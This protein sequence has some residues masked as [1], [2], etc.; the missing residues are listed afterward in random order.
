MA[1]G[2]IHIDGLDRFKDHF[3]LTVDPALIDLGK[4][5]EALLLPERY[6]V[7]QVVRKRS[8]HFDYAE[9][10]VSS[11]D[12]LQGYPLPN[13]TPCYLN[14]NSEDGKTKTISLHDILIN[15][16]SAIR[17]EDKERKVTIEI[18][19]THAS[20]DTQFMGFAKLLWDEISDIMAEATA[21]GREYSINESEIEY[22][23]ARRAYDFLK[24]GFRESDVWH[25][26]GLDAAVQSIP[27]LTEWP[28]EP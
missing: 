10:T 21:Y 19:D 28:S 12:I 13:V 18:K 27:D 15:G 2:I 14:E 7:E 8:N 22:A 3:D 20:R 1:Q 16:V 5:K 17:E 25:R 9:I 4:L 6:T 26:K 24:H 11:P 23:I